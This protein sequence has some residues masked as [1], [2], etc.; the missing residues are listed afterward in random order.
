MD[1]ALSREAL[2]NTFVEGFKDP[3]NLQ[4]GVEWEKIGVYVDTGKAIRYSGPDGVEAIFK[5]LSARFGWRPILSDS[6][7]IALAKDGSSITLEPGGQIELSGRKAPR[8]KEN[9]DELYEHLKEIREVSSEMGIAWLGTGVQPVS[10]VDE[11]EW[12]PKR[13]YDIMREA[14][15]NNGALTTSMMKQTAS[16]Q[17]SVDVTDEADAVEK[18]RLAMGLA[19]LLSALF[20]NSPIS[21]GRLNGFF[22]RRAHIWTRTAPERTGILEKVFTKPDFGIDDYVEYALTVPMFFIIRG[23]KWIPMN[24]MTFRDFH[25]NGF[26][27]FRAA[28]ADWELHLTTIFTEA[29][30]KKYLEI[31][32]IDCQRTEL[33]LAAPALIKGI[34][35]DASSRKKAWE[36]VADLS[37]EERRRL[38]EE[39]PAEGLK[40]KF[41]GKTLME[42]VLEL[43]KL[44]E[45][46]LPED[47]KGYLKPL[48][49]LV[50]GRGMVPAQIL[51][52]CFDRDLSE[53]G[54]VQRLIECAS[55]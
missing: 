46:G 2:R 9:F 38:A 6:H 8:L 14:L 7:I 12:V 42:P 36:L 44:G 50:T 49:D 37:L 40:T 32:S 28:Q 11:I 29:R 22:S 4:I 51:M 26:R 24:G 13:R 25:K 20:A 1:A 19:P 34:F 17:I 31:R 5:E 35:Y 48:K 41:K 52:N 55:I 33:G 30:L 43:L 18:L 15:K 53:K 47:E 45:G 10:P 39:A 21:E 23:D 3:Q 54:A 16:I 27:E